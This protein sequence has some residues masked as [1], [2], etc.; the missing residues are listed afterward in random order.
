MFPFTML[1]LPFVYSKSLATAIVEWRL[2]SATVKVA[3]M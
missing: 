2:L 1:A 3:S